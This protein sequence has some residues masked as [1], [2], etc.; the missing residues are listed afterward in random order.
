MILFW[1]SLQSPPLNRTHVEETCAWSE[2][3][4][5]LRIKITSNLLRNVCQGSGMIITVYYVYKYYTRSS[6]TGL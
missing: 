1:I 4:D 6:M 5:F 3:W 2:S